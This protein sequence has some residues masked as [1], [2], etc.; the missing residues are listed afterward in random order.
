MRIFRNSYA[1]PI[2]NPFFPAMGRIYIHWIYIRDIYPIG[3]Y[4]IWYY[5]QFWNWILIYSTIWIWIL[6]ILCC[7]YIQKFSWIGD[8]DIYPIFAS[9]YGYDIISKKS[10]YDPVLISNNDNTFPFFFFYPSQH[11]FFKHNITSIC[12]WYTCLR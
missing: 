12:R 1:L 9:G 5:I 7:E 2:I 8:M 11:I 10:G 4:M 3:G 6:D